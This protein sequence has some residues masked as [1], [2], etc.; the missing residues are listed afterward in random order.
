[1]LILTAA[2]RRETGMKRWSFQIPPAAHCQIIRGD[3]VPSKWISEV[4]TLKAGFGWDRCNPFWIAGITVPQ[5]SE[6][7]VSEATEKNILITPLCE[8]ETEPVPP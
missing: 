1:V 6:K 8:E 7:G 4:R 2:K 5:R 3:S